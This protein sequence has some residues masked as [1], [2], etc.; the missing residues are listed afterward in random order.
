V[1]LVT[2]EPG[3]AGPPG[4]GEETARM[5]Y[6]LTCRECGGPERPLPIPFGSAAERGKW[7]AEHTRATGHSRWTVK[8]EP[9]SVVPGAVVADSGELEAG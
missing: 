6:L 9:R 5:F 8:D 2:G 1:R 3:Q 4:A 7:A